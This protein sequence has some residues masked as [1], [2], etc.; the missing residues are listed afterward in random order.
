M[1]IYYY[2]I[3]DFRFT[4]V[5]RREKKWWAIAQPATPFFSSY[6]NAKF[7]NQKNEVEE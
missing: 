4:P 2:V 6:D 5:G 1:K 3:G 7:Q